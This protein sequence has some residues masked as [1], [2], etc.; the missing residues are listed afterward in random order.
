MIK[1]VDDCVFFSGTVGIGAPGNPLYGASVPAHLRTPVLRHSASIPASTTMATNFYQ[2]PS[3]PQ[4]SQQPTGPHFVQSNNA[5]AAMTAMAATNKY[6]N[7]NSINNN[8]TAATQSPLMNHAYNA[9][10]MQQQAPSLPIS[11]VPETPPNMQH[12]IN[13]AQMP[14]LNVH[15]R[16]VQEEN[17]SEVGEDDVFD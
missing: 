16:P 17:S 8:Q 11:T 4:M 13:Y 2:A 5:S 10:S 7:N 9:Q 3:G 1:S 14:T 6:F 12:L 15:K